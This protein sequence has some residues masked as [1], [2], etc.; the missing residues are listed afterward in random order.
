MA[1]FPAGHHEQGIGQAVQVDDHV[2]ADRLGRGERHDQA[3]RATAHRPRHVEAGGADRPSRQDEVRQR[4]ELRRHPLDRALEGGDVPLLDPRARLRAGWALEDRE[5][6]PQVKE[7]VLDP[8]QLGGERGLQSV[9]EGRAD[10]GVQ[11]V[12]GPERLDPK[13]VLRDP[14]PG[15]ER[16]R[17]VVAG[18]RRDLRQPRHRP[19]ILQDTPARYRRPGAG[20]T[21][22]SFKPLEKSKA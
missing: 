14:L 3:L 21:N 13:G 12:D 22:V 16:G 19:H 1:I 15:S 5:V 8:R 7:V 18:L 10:D 4:A 20:V 2:G 11:L 6:A 9:R 17:S